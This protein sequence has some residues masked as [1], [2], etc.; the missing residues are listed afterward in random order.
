V[1]GGQAEEY[2][3]FLA[4]NPQSLLGEEEAMQGY[5]AGGSSHETGEN[6]F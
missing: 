4:V 2:L 1:E 6:D 5:L 3:E